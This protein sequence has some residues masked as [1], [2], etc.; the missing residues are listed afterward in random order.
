[1][2]PLF[3]ASALCLSI[4][5]LSACT[6]SQTAFEDDAGNPSYPQVP[7]ANIL[8]SNPQLPQNS[9]I[10]DLKPQT[11]DLKDELLITKE[12]LDQEWYF[13]SKRVG[14]P[15]SW[16]QQE[17]EGELAWM[18]EYFASQM[19]QERVADICR[20]TGGTYR[21]SCSETNRADCQHGP[22]QCLCPEGTRDYPGDEGCLLYDE[23]N[24]K[25]PLV[26]D[27]EKAQGFYPGFKKLGT[28]EHWVYYAGE[29]NPKSIKDEAGW[30][31]PDIK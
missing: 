21:F 5:I 26:T 14:T 1:M 19:E 12:E 25:F 10:E 16:I 31:S 13:G 2:K 24:E 4:L 3:L 7:Q 17:K 20:E 28:F 11:P 29:A 18:S 22:T 23:E 27:E 8:N 6:S 9:Q 30:R 15:A